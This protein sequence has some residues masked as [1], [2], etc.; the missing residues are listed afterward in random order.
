MHQATIAKHEHTVNDMMLDNINISIA[1]CICD[2]I[3]HTTK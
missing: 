2:N 3:C 1:D